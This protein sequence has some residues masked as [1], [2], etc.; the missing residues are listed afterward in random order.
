MNE[1][2][3]KGKKILLS[4]QNTILSAAAIIA[5]MTIT[6]QVL[7][8]VRQRIVLHFFSPA[9]ASLFFAALKLPELLFEVLIYGMFSSAFIPVF[10]KAF[11]RSEKEAWDTAGRVVTIGLLIFLGF[12]LV[13]GIF[14]EQIYSAIAPGYTHEQIVMIAK[15]ARILFVSQAIFIVSYVLTSV[16]ESLRRFLIPA[17]APVFY[18][19]GLI[20]GTLF[21][22][23]SLGLLG[24]TIGVVIGALIHLL[25]QLPL[26][27]KLG[28]RFTKDTTPNEGV[29][30]IGKLALPRIADLS[31]QQVVDMSVLYFSSLISAASYT[32]FTLANSLQLAP[33]RLFG[34]SLAK[35]AL[36]T[37]TRESD[38]PKQFKATLLK[39]FYQI[40]FLTLPFA[41]LF[42]VLRIPTIRLLFGTSIFDWDST[43]ET[44]MVLSAFA[45]GIPFQATVAL[46]ARSFYAI[47]DT[48]T[49][50]T[51]SI[52]GD[53]LIILGNFILIRVFGFPA[54]SLGASFSIGAIVETLVLFSLLHKKMDL[55][56]KFSDFVP[57]IKSLTSAVLS[58]GVMFFL[59]KFFDKWV[60]VTQLKRPIPFERFVLDTSYTINLIAL[61]VFVAVCGISIYVITSFVFKSQELFAITRSV[62]KRRVKVS[63]PVTIDNT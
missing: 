62:L 1:L 2:L 25:I 14:A 15:L 60:W 20:A 18:N 49:P 16:L 6:S 45:V 19:I 53:G 22:S 54:W 50:V 13:F 17:L 47:H 51:V 30:D 8:L 44:G 23:P 28:F 43:V 5:A 3:R 39:T 26:A 59:L 57:V 27:L 40:F 61:T 38:D 7:G 34:I 4:E 58:G 12:A 36:P 52:V 10:T 35:A 48:R 9:E 31:F 24:P 32:Y 41:T 37:L 46:L 29:R 63:E 56:S 42:I 11:K 33:V 55:L 21:L